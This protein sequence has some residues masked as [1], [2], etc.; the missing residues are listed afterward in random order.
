MINIDLPR[1]AFKHGFAEYLCGYF[2]IGI[3]HAGHPRAIGPRIAAVKICAVQAYPIQCVGR[4]RLGEKGGYHHGLGS[5]GAERIGIDVQ[6]GVRLAEYVGRVVIGKV[7]GTYDKVLVARNI[8]LSHPGDVLTGI[9]NF[10]GILIVAIQ[11]V[12]DRVK[13]IRPGLYIK[14]P[15]T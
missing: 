14:M 2:A 15:R 5:Q 10:E 4:K 3:G 1:Q 8:A 6:Q 7:V 13:Q 11:V 9:G 12:N